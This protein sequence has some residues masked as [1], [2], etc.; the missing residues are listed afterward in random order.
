MESMTIVVC[1][2]QVPAVGEVQIDPQNNTLIREG[3]P[4]IVNPSDLN[5]LESALVL[6]DDLG[7]QVIA[8]SMGPRQAEEALRCCLEMGADQA[9]LLCDP[10]F[11]GSDTLA[12]A[13]ALA[14]AINK[15]AKH[16]S[17]VLCGHESMDG[18]TAQVG[19]EIG[20]LLGIAHANNVMKMCLASERLVIE[21]KSGACLETQEVRLPCL[22]SIQ[23]DANVPRPRKATSGRV[24]VIGSGDLR[25]TESEVGLAGSATRVVRIF[26]PRPIKSMHPAIDSS[27]PAHRR[28]ELI[29]AGGMESKKN[30]VVLEEHGLDFEALARE[31]QPFIA[32]R[33]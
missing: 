25:V 15:I 6:K 33:A 19:P 30:Q 31:L 11:A 20:E 9:W 1:I 10:A 21:R 4:S 7:A 14:K 27:L 29:L 32:D 2:K 23:K 22:I 24:Q 13:R 12:T 5:A 16:Y 18:N 8:L 3:V 17:L 26:P 28:I